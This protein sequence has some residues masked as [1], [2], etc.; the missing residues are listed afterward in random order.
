MTNAPE[1]L[2][3]E[4]R[5]GERFL[6]T[7]HANPDGDAIGSE[8][9]LARVLRSLGKGTVIWNHDATPRVYL[10]LP[11]SERIHHGEEPPAGYPD[12]FDAL[13]TLECPTFERSGLHELLGDKLPILNIDHHLGNEHYGRVNWVDTAAPS[14]GEMIHRLARALNITL[15]AATATSLYLTLV[16][17]TG[18]FR[19]ANATVRAFEAAAELVKDGAQPQEVARWLYESQPE[20]AVRLLGEALRTLEIEADGRVATV[21]LE[22][23]MAERAGAEPGDSEGLIDVPRSIAG[24]DAVAVIRE[25]GPGRCKASLRSRGDIDVERIARAQGGGGHRNAAG[26]A[27]EGEC[28]QVRRAV[29]DSL[30]AALTPES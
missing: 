4:L 11:G 12:A 22:R 16:T 5:S 15:D 28:A 29:A 20:S 10:S 26:F 8:V 9:G 17:D 7:S 14:L 13:V 19:F 21:V 18:N 3:R 27:A 24:V 1:D 2:L 25:I 6:L 23:E 30:T